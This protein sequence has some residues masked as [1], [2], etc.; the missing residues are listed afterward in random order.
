MKVLRN[1][2]MFKKILYSVT[3]LF[4]VL[5]AWNSNVL[6]QSNPVG[7]GNTN[8]VSGG[9][10]NTMKLENPLESDSILEFLGAI[11]DIIITFAI[12]I[13]VLYIMYAGFMLVTA[14]GDTT[15]IA[16][17]KTALTWALVGGVL[18]LGADLL[19]TVIES[20]VDSI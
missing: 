14:R 16:T 7:G 6:A 3:L 11:F 8:P 12:P 18:I 19:I 15:K 17:G 10:I 13:I 5:F 9:N 4:F 2:I 20:T 1:H